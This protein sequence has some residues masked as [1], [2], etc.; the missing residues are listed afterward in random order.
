MS[1]T[2]YVD[3]PRS[4]K[5]LMAVLRSVPRMEAVDL[6]KDWTV[7][8]SDRR[9]SDVSEKT[10]IDSKLGKGVVTDDL[11]RSPIG[12]T[13]TGDRKV[14]YLGRVAL[15]PGVYNLSEGCFGGEGEYYSNFVVCNAQ[16]RKRL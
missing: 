3:V 14:G 11:R 13:G 4:F 1:Y 6:R 5:R 8:D 2:L 7:S 15:H 16:P 12:G 9:A 10:S